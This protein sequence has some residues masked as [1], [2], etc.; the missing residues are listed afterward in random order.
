M[1]NLI[2]RIKKYHNPYQYL[3]IDEFQD[4][5]PL[6]MKLIN[7]LLV[8]RQVKKFYFVGDD[9]QSIY[10]FSGSRVELFINLLKHSEAS[11]SFINNTYRNSQQLIEITSKYITKDNNMIHKYLQSKKEHFYPIIIYEYKVKNSYS[12]ETN[13]SEIVARLI[14]KHYQEDKNYEFLILARTNISI[15]QLWIDGYFYQKNNKSTTIFLKNFPQAKIKFITVHASKNL[16]RIFLI[17]L[18]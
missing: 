16:F 5:S 4:V 13:Q 8:D 7:Q 3:I 17:K 18:K 14:E 12:E 11:V 1:Y 10:G 15:E 2:I 6:R 9:W